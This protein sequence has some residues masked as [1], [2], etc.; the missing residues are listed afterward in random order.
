MNNTF[1]HNSTAIVDV[2]HNGIQDVIRQL[3][4]HVVIGQV[5]ERAIING[6]DVHTSNA[7]LAACDETSAFTPCSLMSLT[8]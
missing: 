1:S 7:L 8:F 4:E 3:F 2:L 5:I 6:L